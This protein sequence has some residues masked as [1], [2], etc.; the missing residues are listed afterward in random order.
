MESV[1]KI[2]GLRKEYDEFVLDDISWDVPKGYIMGLIGPNGAGKTT[3]IKLIMNLIRPESGEIKVFG[4]DHSHNEKE[5]KNRI[6]YV[7]EEQYFYEFRSPDWTGKFV[8]HFYNDWD[9]V[10]FQNLLEEFQ[11]PSKK[12]IR[13]LSKG[14]KV[15]LSL[16]LAISHNPELI[17]LDEP[18]SGLDPVIRRDVL[19]F[20]QTVTQEGNTSVIISS[21]ITADIARIADYITYMVNGRIALV[22]AKDDLQANWKKIHFSKGT[23]DERIILILSKVEDH[24][25]GSSGITQK[26]LEIKDALKKGIADGDIKIENVGLDDILISLV[27]GK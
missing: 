23:L 26:Y 4:L 6:G 25:F 22:A 9:A 21:H 27:K 20:L 19:D 24:M 11:I 13:K 3:T 15:K 5:I 16:A 8:S 12:M 2:R 1:L 17:I 18:T 7:G 14:M 10:K